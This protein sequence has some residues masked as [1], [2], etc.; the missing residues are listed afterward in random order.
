MKELKDSITLAKK[1]ITDALILLMNEKD[2]D[3]IS[4]TEICDK[5]GVSRMTY[6]R[7]YYNKKDII[8]DCLKDIAEKFR[9]ESHSWREKNKYHN[10]EV[11]N[12]LFSYFKKY[13]Y[14]I[15]TLKKANL[16][17]LLQDLLNKYLIREANTPTDPQELYHLYSYSG[18]LYNVYMKWIDNG[19]KESSEEMAEIFCK[20][21]KYI[22]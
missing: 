12:F 9:R 16:T 20:A 2:F 6:Y 17:G 15:T 14:F 4:I 1:C 21:N 22:W 13:A 3:K 8:V 18:A 7:N 10:K 19:M 5:A 11:I